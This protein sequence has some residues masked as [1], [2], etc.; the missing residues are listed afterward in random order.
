MI[1][2]A[3]YFLKQKAFPFFSNNNAE[4]LLPGPN[5]T[6]LMKYALKDI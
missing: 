2:G 3:K 4:T 1:P 6:A 5:W